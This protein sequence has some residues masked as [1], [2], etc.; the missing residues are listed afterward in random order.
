MIIVKSTGIIRRVDDLGR[1]V[2]PKEIRS[3]LEVNEKDQVE[4]FVEGNNVII[5][6]YEEKCCFCGSTDNLCEY[7]SKLIC[8]NCFSN[9][10]NLKIDK[11]E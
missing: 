5:Q 3:S 1:V 9:I 11:I 4:F 8:K 2:I 10:K 7:K 6:K